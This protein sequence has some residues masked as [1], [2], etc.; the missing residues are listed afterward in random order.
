MHT[1][2]LGFIPLVVFAGAL[3]FIYLL[4]MDLK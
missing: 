3:A 2:V 4:A 1:I